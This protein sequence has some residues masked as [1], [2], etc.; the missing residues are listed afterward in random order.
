VLGR[1][2][3]STEDVL[4]GDELV[5]VDSPVAAF[6]VGRREPWL[7]TVMRLFTELGGVRVVVPLLLTVG[8]L[9]RWRSLSWRLIVLL[10]LAATGAV[11]ASTSIKLI[12]ARP[13]PDA[14]ALVNAL[15][16]GFPSG[17]STQAAALAV[18]ALVGISRVYLGVHEPTDVLGDWA[19]GSLWTCGVLT[20]MRLV[21]HRGTGP[22]VA[23]RQ[24]S[25]GTGCVEGAAKWQDSAGRRGG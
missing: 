23:M 7:T 17:H 14:N 5:R 1:R 16:Y 25:G 9:A 3:G 20:A 15:G 22:G 6:L 12:V 18:G 2:S 19:L 21:E 13:R 4:A 8:L 24:E 10:V 11:L